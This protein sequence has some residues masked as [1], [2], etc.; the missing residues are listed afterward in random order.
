MLKEMTGHGYSTSN[1]PHQNSHNFTNNYMRTTTKCREHKRLPC[2]EHWQSV[3][4]FLA[5]FSQFRDIASLCT[6]SPHTAIACSD[7]QFEDLSH[8][9]CC[10]SERDPLSSCTSL[11]SWCWKP[12]EVHPWAW[13]QHT[14]TINKDSISIEP[15][16]KWKE[17]TDVSIVTDDSYCRVRVGWSI[18]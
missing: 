4:L 17:S 15:N 18:L 7:Q 2:S 3:L 6:K 14:T 5:T 11:W 8:S 9:L 13:T 12:W 10:A 16:D 1:S